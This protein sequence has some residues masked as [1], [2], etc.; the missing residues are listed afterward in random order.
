MA[1]LGFGAGKRN[2]WVTLSRAVE[3]SADTTLFTDLSPS[4]AWAAILPQLGALDG[5]ATQ[6]LVEIDYHPEVSVDTR[7]VYEDASRPV[8]KTT[9]ELFVR[10]VQNLEEAGVVMR[11]IC[12]EIAP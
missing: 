6:H 2:T 4:G 10:S 11:L 7:I 5:R 3:S 1:R 8:G 9:R 12:E